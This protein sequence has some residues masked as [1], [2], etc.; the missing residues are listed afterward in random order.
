MRKR[1]PETITMKSVCKLISLFAFTLLLAACDGGIKGTGGPVIDMEGSIDAVDGSVDGGSGGIQ[2]STTADNQEE[3]DDMTMLPGPSGMDPVP[4]APE[5]APDQLPS[6][7]NFATTFDATL[8]SD[9][10]V[11]VIHG[12]NGLGPVVAILN[13]NVDM[14]LVASPG[15]SFG[16]GSQQYLSLVADSYELDLLD[17]NQFAQQTGALPV[18]LAGVYPLTLSEGSASTLLL[19]GLAEPQD[20]DAVVTEGETGEEFGYPLEVLAVPNL[21]GTESADSV[22]IRIVHAA[23]LFD[24]AGSVDI[25]INS[26]SAPSATSGIPIFEDFDYVDAN[27]GYYETAH[28]SY[29]ITVTEP[30]GLTLRIPTLEPLMATPGSSTTIILLDDPDGVAG[31]DVKVLILNDGDRSGL[32]Q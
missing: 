7:T 1:N 10:L 30:N 22:Q 2:E 29:Y 14:P 32:D 17:A 28:D 20:P 26:T 23:P 3:P 6:D 13:Q 18:Q 19:R 25:F 11:K 8:R 12:V 16:E 4:T 31:M 9:A 5:V 15:L 21:L 24:G 27:T